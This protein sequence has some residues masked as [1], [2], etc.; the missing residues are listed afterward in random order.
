[1]TIIRVEE[2]GKTMVWIDIRV[3]W[4]VREGVE[5]R[6][7]KDNKRAMNICRSFQIFE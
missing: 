5:H 4:F 6:Y 7:E 3:G 1:M 2:G